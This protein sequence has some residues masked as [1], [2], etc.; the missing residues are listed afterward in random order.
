MLEEDKVKIKQLS[1]A[2]MTLGFNMGVVAFRLRLLE[3]IAPYIDADVLDSKL[4]TV[5]DV[6]NLIVEA[7]Q[8]FQTEEEFAKMRVIMEGLSERNND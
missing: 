7:M 5:R 8:E 4:L 3:T 6:M 1:T 2:S